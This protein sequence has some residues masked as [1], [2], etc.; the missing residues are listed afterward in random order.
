MD[1]DCDGLLPQSLRANIVDRSILLAGSCVMRGE[2]SAENFINY[3]V[4]TGELR[5]VE[6][7][8]ALL[9]LLTLLKTTSKKTRDLVTRCE[10]YRLRRTQFSRKQVPRF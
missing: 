2:R 7:I 9:H 10:S 5:Y 6:L 3:M 1:V 8:V 4:R